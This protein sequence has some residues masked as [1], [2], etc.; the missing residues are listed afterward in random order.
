MI[1]PRGRRR[2][3]A[4]VVGV[5]AGLLGAAPAQ[6][7]PPRLNAFPGC[8]ALFQY[9]KAKASTYSG[10][11]DRRVMITPS[12]PAS[13]EDV[14]GTRAPAPMA[15]TAPAAGE[16]TVSGTNNQ[17]QGVDEPDIVKADARRIVTISDGKLLIIDIAG[18]DPRIVGTLE[19]DGATELLV[20]G[21]RAL[22]FGT[23]YDDV[24]DSSAPGVA[25][26]DVAVGR[27]RHAIP[28]TVLTEVD[29]SDD[30]APKVRRS[31][32]LDGHYVTAR[33]VGHTAR[34]VIAST[35]AIAT[36]A[37]AAS[38]GV[39][40]FVPLTTIASKL[41]GRQYRRSVVPCNQVRRPVTYAGLGLT[42]VLSVDMRDGL[43][44]VDRD[45]V[46]ADA[47]TVY[48]STTGL[49]I[50]S[51]RYLRALSTVD[52]VP[53]DIRTELHRFDTSKEGVARYR[54][55]GSVRG[56]VLNQFSLSDDAGVLRVATT[57]EPT[58]LAS[59]AQQTESESF[60]TTFHVPESGPLTQLGQVGG[61]GKGE[62]IYAVRFLGDVGYVVTFR[63]V[64]PLYT[65]D[66]SDPAAPKVVGELKIPGYSS[67]LHP[68]GDN[69]LIGVGQSANDQGRTSGTQVSLFDVSDPAAPKLR[70]KAVYPG[71]YST[72]ESDHL[73]FLWWKPRNLAVV[74]ISGG[75]TFGAVG[76]T[77]AGG[78][79][80]EAGRIGAANDSVLRSVVIGTRLY[81]LTYQQLTASSL[82]TLKPLGSL[83]L[84]V[85]AAQPG[86][87]V[88]VATSPPPVAVP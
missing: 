75:G 41:T 56:L 21:D 39:R 18:A 78:A 31:M 28:K 69:L 42:S 86:V 87:P 53:E 44:N 34:V 84:P 17:E 46:L 82:T 60:V 27:Y 74:P 79:L 2:T 48:A 72:A 54:G 29:L 64:D 76:L 10:F 52:Q 83:D 5:V 16:E 11:I 30:A 57:S 40:R 14:T 58:W 26:S 23:V 65:V 36:A 81:T 9:A 88:P 77:V 1:G 6:A 62:R 85:P 70:D 3:S 50:A 20:S 38:A 15:T 8:S 68:L 45:A 63:Q 13:T 19:I 80:S 35:P 67:Y 59:G 32:T 25:P 37:E 33:L 71:A 51:H 49:Y 61:L 4:V 7:A 47:D 24:P 55:S 43:Q 66:L 73:A 12:G 22:V